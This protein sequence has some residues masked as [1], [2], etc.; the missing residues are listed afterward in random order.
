MLILHVNRS[1]LDVSDMQAAPGADAKQ[2]VMR[3]RIHLVHIL[4]Q[5]FKA[6]EVVAYLQVLIDLGIMQPRKIAAFS[7]L[8]RQVPQLKP[9]A[10]Y[11]LI[12]LQVLSPDVL[13]GRDEMLLDLHQVRI[14]EHKH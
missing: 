4:D 11:G 5:T 3:G 2:K 1:E 13:A 10:L 7:I 8:A 6:R 12:D 9:R 14:A